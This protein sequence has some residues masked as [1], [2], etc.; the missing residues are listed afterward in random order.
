MNNFYTYAYL[1]E[2]GTPY[3]IGKGSNGRAYSTYRRSIKIPKDKDRILFLKQNLTEEDAFKHEKYM[4]HVLGRK[5]LGTGIL[6]N[7]TD[8]GEGTSGWVPSEETRK[9]M[10][11]SRRGV[12]HHMFGKT[13]S[14]E[15]R[16]KLSDSICGEKHYMFGKKHTDETIKKLSEYRKGKIHTDEIKTKISES[17]RGEKNPMYGKKHSEET[18]R[19]ISESAKNRG[20]KI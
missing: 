2:D 11:E 19:K 14:D 12:K 3:Y 15:S 4:I 16:K 10:S 8:G 20:K 13:H 5:D 9:R 18:K 7:L 6:R 17:L 1:R